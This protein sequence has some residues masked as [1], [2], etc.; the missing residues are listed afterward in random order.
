MRFKKKNNNFFYF[1]KNK[2]KPNKMKYKFVKNQ[3]FFHV[4]K[5][6]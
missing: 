4:K 5:I 2:I 3:I 6:I 1:L